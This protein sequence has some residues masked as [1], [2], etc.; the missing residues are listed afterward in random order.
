MK[1]AIMIVLPSHFAWEISSSD[2]SIPEPQVFSI[3]SFIILFLFCLSQMSLNIISFQVLQT[4][5][6]LW[7]LSR[8]SRPTIII[9]SLNTSSGNTAQ[10]IIYCWNLKCCLTFASFWFFGS[11][12]VSYQLLSC[13]RW[14]LVVLD[15]IAVTSFSI[16]LFNLLLLLFSICVSLY[17]LSGWSLLRWHWL[18]Y[19][20]EDF[21]KKSSIR[22]L[23]I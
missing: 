22:Y 20:A 15:A 18:S 5:L 21:Y 8:L 7:R 3:L 23:Y 1:T 9:I 19:T 12:A 13:S 4:C 2:G 10:V 14:Q 16:H 17:P 11:S 6:H